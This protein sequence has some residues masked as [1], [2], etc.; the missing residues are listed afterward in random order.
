M[1]FLEELGYLLIIRKDG[2]QMA[3]GKLPDGSTTFRDPP[4]SQYAFEHLPLLFLHT[5]LH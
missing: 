4:P 1:F 2:N 5:E 3:E